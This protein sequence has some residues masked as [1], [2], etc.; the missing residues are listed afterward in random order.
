MKNDSPIRYSE[1]DYSLLKEALARLWTCPSVLASLTL[2][3]WK[4]ITVYDGPEISGRM[5]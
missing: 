2:E 5:I 3:D 1:D 4:A